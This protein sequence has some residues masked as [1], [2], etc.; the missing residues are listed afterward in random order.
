MIIDEL[1]SLSPAELD[2]VCD[3]IFKLIK[4]KITDTT[5]NDENY[6]ERPCNCPHCKSERIIK[7]GFNNGRQKYLCKD[8]KK[9]FSNTTKHYSI[10]QEVHIQLGK[11]SLNVNLM[12]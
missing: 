2:Y 8:C 6:T 7:Y 1:N 10:V 11:H 5:S 3:Y 4:E 9:L 12:D